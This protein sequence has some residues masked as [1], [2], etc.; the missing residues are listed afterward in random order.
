MLVRSVKGS[1]PSPGFSWPLLC[2]RGQSQH[3]T[4]SVLEDTPFYSESDEDTA[5]YSLSHLRRTDG[6]VSTDDE[7]DEDD[8]DAEYHTP[9]GLK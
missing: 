1:G 8:E 4:H 3:S 5:T 2:K 6:S 9:M 7:D